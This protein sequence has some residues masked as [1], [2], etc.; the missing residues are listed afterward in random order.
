MDWSKTK[1]IF[2]LAFLVLD[3]YLAMEFFELRDKSDYAIIQEATIEERL[4]AEGIV[5]NDLP[6][7][8]NKSFYITAKSKD[9]TIEEVAKLEGQRVELPKSSLEGEQSFR[10][11]NM[12]LDKPFPLP[13]VNTQSKITQFLKDNVISGDQ[14]HYWYTDDQKNSIICIQN[15][16]NRTIF[17]T[18]ND[19]IGMVILYL[20]EDNEIISYEQS[21]LEEIKEV[22]EKESAITA[23]KAIEALYKNNYLTPNSE[24]VDIE[25]G[26]YTHTPLSNQQILAPTWHLIVE[27]EDK[28][29]ED[30]YVNAL[31]GDVLQLTE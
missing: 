19:H 24:V 29:K 8:I 11:I 16:N 2:I 3:V 28:E 17:Q 23:L 18:K 20:N 22:E 12:L 5:Y 26:Y 25:Y 6:E 30:Y 1:T 27:K 9:F 4:E 14:Y 21:M 10:T 7:D 31:E 13:D 15:Y